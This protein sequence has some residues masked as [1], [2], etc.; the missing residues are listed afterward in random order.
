MPSIL[1]ETGF[2]T[3]TEE[4]EYINSEKGQDEIVAQI[5]TAIKRYKASLEGNGPPPV[6]QASPSAAA[7]AARPDSSGSN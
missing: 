2:I 6:Q 7:P 1:V 5:V 4:E 3:Q